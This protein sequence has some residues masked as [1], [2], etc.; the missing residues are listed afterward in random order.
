MGRRDQ[1]QYCNRTA[2]PTKMRR[3]RPTET[4]TAAAV[5]VAYSGYQLT[6]TTVY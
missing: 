5:T 4:T 6:L 1:L 2:M 3:R